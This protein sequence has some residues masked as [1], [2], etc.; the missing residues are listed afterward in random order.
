MSTD[1]DLDD[2]DLV[3]RILDEGE[4]VFSHHWDSGGPGGSGAEEVYHWNGKF[5]YSSLDL[6]PEGPFDNLGEA[7][8]AADL[9]TV[10]EATTRI[11]CSALSAVEL[12]GRLE[13]DEEVEIRINGQP[14]T[15]RA[16]KWKRSRPG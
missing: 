3:D 5:L 4:V 6:D 8:G 9:L 15:H 12:V 7:L 1:D 11:N 10:T 2:Y 14:W 16:G 13:C